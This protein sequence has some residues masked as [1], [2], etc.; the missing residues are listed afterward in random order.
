ML[1]MR[2]KLLLT[3]VCRDVRDSMV[4]KNIL[5]GNNFSDTFVRAIKKLS[6]VGERYAKQAVIPFGSLGFW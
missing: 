3:P 2:W 1:D 5:R 6:I 4:L